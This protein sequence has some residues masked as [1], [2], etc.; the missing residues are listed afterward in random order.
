MDAETR[1]YGLIGF[2]ARHSLSPAMHN[3]AFRE[4]GMNAVYLAFEVAPERLKMAV[5]GVRGLGIHGLNVTMPHKTTVIEHLDGLSGE[6]EE[7]GSVNTIVNDGELIGYNTDGVGARRALEMVTSLRGKNV[8]IIGAGGAGRAIAYALSKVS[9]VVVLNRTPEKARALERFGVTGDR[10][11][12]ENLRRYLANADVLIN[13]TPV[14][15]NSDESPVPA[16]LLREGLVVMDIVYKPLK[17]RLLREAERRGCV[18]VDGLWMLV[19]QGAE[20][21]RLWTGK[22]VDPELMRRAALEGLR[23]GR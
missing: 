13:A 22:S 19:H 4:L 23:K 6:A 3:A 17:T 2:P 12:P 16:E 18:T 21:F 20:S 7:I 10:L 8:L 1:L 5:D 9:E 15:M 11:T 14:G